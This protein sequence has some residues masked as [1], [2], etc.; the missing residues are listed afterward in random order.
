MIQHDY[1]ANFALIACAF[2]CAFAF[3]HKFPRKKLKHPTT[4]FIV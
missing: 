4:L 1:G 2:A 3:E